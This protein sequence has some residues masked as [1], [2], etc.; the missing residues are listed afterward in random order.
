M[1]L[2]KVFRRKKEPIKRKELTAEQKIAK[3]VAIIKH[4]TRV[5]NLNKE[6]EQISN[7]LEM[8]ELD[9]DSTKTE[10]EKKSDTIIRRITLLKY[11]IDIREGLIKWLS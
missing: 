4:R 1:D 6:L 8:T 11:E 9:F 10:R 2:F 7:T 3:A 5:A